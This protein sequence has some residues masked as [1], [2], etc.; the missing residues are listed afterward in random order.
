MLDRRHEKSV[1]PGGTPRQGAA[2][3]KLTPLEERLSMKVLLSFAAAVA[4]CAFAAGPA[5]AG[6]T[7]VI[8]QSDGQTNVYHDVAIK[9]IHG[10]LFMTSADGKGT[11]VIHQAA[12]SYQGNLMV[13]FPTAVTLIQAGQTSPI[14]VRT[15]TVYVN[16]TDDPQQL[17]LSTVKVPPHSIMLSMSTK[18]GT[19]VSLVGRIDKVVK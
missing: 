3:S 11:M 2:C 13:C 17:A 5:L 16:S 12:C 7:V 8:R 18:R 4:V 19:F 15:G 14:T 6:G 10:A 1:K 9:V